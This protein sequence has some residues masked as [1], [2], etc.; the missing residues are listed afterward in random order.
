MLRLANAEVLPFEFTGF[1]DNI[2]K[3]VQDAEKLTDSMREQ[4]AEKNQRVQ[5]KTFQAFSDPT[6]T[7]VTPDPE[8][9]V[10]HLNFAPLQ[11][12]VANLEKGADEYAKAY[13]NA[14]KGSS[15]I[16][17]SKLTDLNSIL[18]QSERALT[19]K[20]GL[21]GRAWFRHQ[22]DAPGVYTGY[23]AKALPGVQEA[24]IA[25]NWKLAD[26]QIVFAAETLNAF[27]AEVNRAASVLK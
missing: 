1:A 26:E 8:P 11:N 16:P 12:A 10:P 18:M 23:E 24:I 20:E 6:K 7:F 19:R 15:S 13:Q 4:V 21:P 25:K 14:M 3:Y 17:A 9:P 22:I 2:S 5:D 27:T